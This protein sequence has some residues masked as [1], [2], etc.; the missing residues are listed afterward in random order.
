MPA[1]IYK[2]NQ[3]EQGISVEAPLGLGALGSCVREGV[4]HFDKL[5]LRQVRR[6]LHRR[7]IHREYRAIQ[8][9]IDR[10]SCWRP[11]MAG[12]GPYR[13]EAGF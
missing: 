9:N 8:S 2:A 1:Q 6:G 3:A 12:D 5:A 13:H 11:G 7:A 4:D 10:V